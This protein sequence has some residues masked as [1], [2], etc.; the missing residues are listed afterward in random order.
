MLRLCCYTGFPL[1]A[2]KEGSS[3]L[4]SL[5]FSLQW[6]L[7]FESTGSR[8]AD[9]ISWG[10]WAL[11]HRVSSC[12]ARTL[13]LCSIW[14][15]PGPGVK[16]CKLHWQVDSS[17]LDQQ[18][19]LPIFISSFVTTLCGGAILGTRETRD[20]TANIH[21][22]IEKANGSKMM[23]KILQ[24]R[25]QQYVNHEFP[26]VQTGFRKGRGTR[27]QI[28]N[29][30]WIVKKEREFQKN[31]Y[32]CF[33]DYAKA[34]DFVDHSKLE[35]SEGNGNIRPSDLPLEKPVCRSGSNS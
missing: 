3:S 12:S 4:Q 14:D 31:I 16:P 28:A 5:G 26:D 32:F 22:I 33:I 23:L 29:I 19:S 7:L 10:P 21:R 24:A 15:L 20:S 13:L 35:N 17:P 11:E 27:D 8:E 6:L 18:G 9:F 30:R 34:F 25:L 1:V 2:A